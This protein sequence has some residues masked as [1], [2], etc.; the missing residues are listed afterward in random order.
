MMNFAC[1]PYHTFH[2]DLTCPSQTDYLISINSAYLHLTSFVEAV[3]NFIEE[4][5]RKSISYYSLE[6]VFCLDYI[7]GTQLEKLD[8]YIC[9]I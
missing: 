5:N 2:G 7:C 4:F 6:L 3:A 8:L 9:T 1:R